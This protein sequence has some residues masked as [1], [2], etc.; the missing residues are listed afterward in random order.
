MRTALEEHLTSSCSL[1]ESLI[2]LNRTTI[3][4]VD[5]ESFTIYE[6]ISS[7]GTI[8]FTQP[9]IDNDNSYFW[10]ICLK[11]GTHT[12]VLSESEWQDGSFLDLH[13]SNGTFIGRFRN[14]HD[15]TSPSYSFIV[16]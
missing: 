2:E 9:I 11:K 4:D 13:Y 6:G 14:D 15:K 1:N 8:V 5:R 10:R 7:S 3:T 16:T 12:I